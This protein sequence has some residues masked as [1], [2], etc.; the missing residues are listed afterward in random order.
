VHILN[1]GV[2]HVLKLRARIAVCVLGILVASALLSSCGNPGKEDE[3]YIGLQKLY[4]AAFGQSMNDLNTHMARAVGNPGLLK[5]DETFRRE[6]RATVM[7]A[8]GILGKM[9]EVKPGR[10]TREAH[11]VLLDAAQHY[12][13]SFTEI[14]FALD[15]W[16]PDTVNVIQRISTDANTTF[17]TYTAR[18]K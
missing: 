6:F 14:L 3:K 4:L 10:A 13:S 5:V 17:S 2:T 16:T 8:W 1:A 15:A 11:K 12:Q 7:D 18:I 9:T